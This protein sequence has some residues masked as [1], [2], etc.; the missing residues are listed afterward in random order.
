MSYMFDIEKIAEESGLADEVIR[1]IR[2]DVRQEFPKDEMMY[3]LHVMRAIE[4]EKNK[5]MRFE[6]KGEQLPQSGDEATALPQ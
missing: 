6:K 3:E 4:S 2:E 5:V 1:R